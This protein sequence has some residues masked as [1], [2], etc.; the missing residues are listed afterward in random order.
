MDSVLLDT[1]FL[2]DLAISTRP[3]SVAAR[4]VFDMS[5]NGTLAAYVASSSLKDFYYIAR[6]ELGEQNR[7]EWISLFLDS[8]MAE[9]FSSAACR[10]ALGSDEPD[11]ED[12]LVR[13]LAESLSVD[14][15]VTRDLVAYGGSKVPSMT[16]EKLLTS[17]D[18]DSLGE[19][20]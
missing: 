19:G 1:N 3:G 14:A 20:R 17:I 9:G 2:L 16:P 15:I 5:T 18:E 12:G 10:A 11:F 6:K 4:Q 13:A 8:F 7:R